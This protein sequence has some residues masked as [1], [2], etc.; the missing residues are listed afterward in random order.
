MSSISGA[1][2]PLTQSTYA[3]ANAAMDSFARYRHSLGLPCVSLALGAISEVGHLHE[4]NEVADKF[5]RIGLYPM[6]QAEFIQAMETA[7]RLQMAGFSKKQERALLADNAASS[8]LLTGLDPRRMNT[9]VASGYEGGSSVH[10]DLKFS[11]LANALKLKAKSGS[12]LIAEAKETSSVA[13]QKLF[14]QKGREAAVA[15]TMK[16]FVEKLS[17]LLLVPV[18]QLDAG[19][20]LVEYGMD[21]MVGSELR[22]WLYREFAVDVSFLEI[23]I[24]TRSIRGMIELIF[25]RMGL[26]KD[27]DK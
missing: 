6:N 3:A 14:T 26:E 7:M 12:S 15:H 24:P 21:S 22:V 9:M 13:V 11:N 25:G 10:L 1:L 8:Y 2:G 19:K 20:S 16:L 5:R 18:E 4:H 17:A 23:S 27:S